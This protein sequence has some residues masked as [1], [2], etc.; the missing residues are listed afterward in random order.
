MTAVIQ[1]L[2]L[3]FVRGTGYVGLIR[4]AED[5]G[6]KSARLLQSNT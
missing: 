3:P 1:C 5:E 6:E 2:P 4:R